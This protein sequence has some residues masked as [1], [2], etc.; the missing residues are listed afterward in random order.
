MVDGSIA[1]Y[2]SATRSWTQKCKRRRFLY[3]F[4]GIV[5]ASAS[6]HK[7]AHAAQAQADSSV[8]YTPVPPIT[9]R[10]P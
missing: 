9:I 10:L 1:A 2:L 7:R 3:P 8:L 6:R 4:L 5:Q